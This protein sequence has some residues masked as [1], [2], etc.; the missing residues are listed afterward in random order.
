MVMPVSGGRVRFT[1]PASGA[2]ATLTGSPATLS[3]SG[4]ASVTATANGIAGSYIVSATATG[5]KIPASFSLTNASMAIALDPAPSGALSLAG[6]AR[7]KIADAVYVDSSSSLALS[8]SRNAS[9]SGADIFFAGFTIYDSL[10]SADEAALMYILAER[11]SADSSR[12]PLAATNSGSG[13]GLK[14]GNGPDNG[15][16]VLRNEMINELTAQ[17]SWAAVDG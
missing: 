17:P 1:P 12:S 4:T 16:T 5:I 14:G 6:N 10:V 2:S 7:I 3:G 11:E 13:R 8:T 9:A 15:R